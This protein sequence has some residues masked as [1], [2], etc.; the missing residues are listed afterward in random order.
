M[1]AA[2][3][4]PKAELT[5]FL[6][7]TVI[8]QT[9]RCIYDLRCTIHALSD[10]IGHKHDLAQWAAC[11]AIH[12]GAWVIRSSFGFSTHPGRNP[13]I[14]RYSMLHAA[15]FCAHRVSSMSYLRLLVYIQLLCLSAWFVVCPYEL[16]HATLLSTHK[17][18]YLYC[19]RET[20]ISRSF[21]S[22]QDVFCPNLD[23]RGALFRANLLLESCVEDSLLSQRTPASCCQGRNM[24]RNSAYLASWT[25]IAL[26]IGENG[27]YLWL[28]CL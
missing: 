14:P 6:C 4:Q 3:S 20:D 13:P 19:I 24:F 22:L 15:F 5:P 21:W 2:N 9:V 18:N 8:A 16:K 23:H 11:T 7:V 10:I 1:R 26:S 25:S 27:L 17:E 28:T 12:S